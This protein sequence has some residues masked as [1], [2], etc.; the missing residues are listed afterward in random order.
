MEL[1]E[2]DEECTNNLIREKDILFPRLLALELEVLE[3][4]SLAMIGNVNKSNDD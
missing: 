1:K 2:F 3:L 4:S